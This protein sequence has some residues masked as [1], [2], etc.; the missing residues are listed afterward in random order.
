MPTRAQATTRPEIKL[1]ATLP[2]PLY[3]QLYQRLRGA[4]LTG[5]VERGA[6]LPSTRA[7]AHELGVSRTTTLLAYEQ[8][9]LEGY[10]ESRKGQGTAVTR[11]LPATLVHAWPDRPPAARPGADTASA[12][13]LAARV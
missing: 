8:L 11:S 7:L 13:H 4:I 1:D 2:T 12:H 3:K 5:Q 10:L 9:I 6:P